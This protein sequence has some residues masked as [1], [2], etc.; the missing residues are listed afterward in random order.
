VSKDATAQF[1]SSIPG[2]PGPPL[3]FQ[4]EDSF[5][6]AVYLRVFPEIPGANRIHQFGVPFPDLPH[7][8]LIRHQ[9][10]VPYQIN[11]QRIK[12]ERGLLNELHNPLGMRPVGQGALHLS[13]SDAEPET[14]RTGEDRKE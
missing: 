6:C 11:T 4:A 14:S 5:D 9:R 7:R 10:E 3:R 8:E 2:D 13:S 12:L 1:L